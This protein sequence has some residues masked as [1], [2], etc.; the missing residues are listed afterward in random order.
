MSPVALKFSPV[1]HIDVDFSMSCVDYAFVGFG[2]ESCNYQHLKDICEG[3]DM[4]K[5]NQKQD[6]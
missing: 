5:I 4:K 6:L 1:L 2:S 3:E